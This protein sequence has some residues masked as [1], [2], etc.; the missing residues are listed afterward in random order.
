MWIFMREI[1]VQS[2]FALLA[3]DSLTRLPDLVPVVYS[4]EEGNPADRSVT[5]LLDRARMTPYISGRFYGPDATDPPYSE[6]AELA[7]FLAHAF[8]THAAAVSRVFEPPPLKVRKGQVPPYSDAERKE[9]GAA[10]Q[11]ALGVKLTFVVGKAAREIRNSLEHA[12]ERLEKWFNTPAGQSLDLIDLNHRP[13]GCSSTS[14]RLSENDFVRTLGDRSIRFRFGADLQDLESM[15]EELRTVLNAA[16]IWQVRASKEGFR[17]P[18]G[19]GSAMV[20]T[21]LYIH[22][23]RPESPHVAALEKAYRFLHEEGFTPDAK[24]QNVPA[25][26]RVI[27]ACGWLSRV[28]PQED[29]FVAKVT[30]P[31]SPEQGKGEYTAVADSWSEEAALAFAFSGLLE[32]ELTA[33]R[34]P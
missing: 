31:A 23:E 14:V 13:F 34:R 20:S 27:N 22:R 5:P 8:L 10:L 32:E 21:D 16:V 18:P 3:F 12:D 30:R 11:R 24:P 9:R 19:P 29:L 6:T 15:A 7:F 28:G 33:Q 26:S 25:L 17:T 4:H 1:S 2:R